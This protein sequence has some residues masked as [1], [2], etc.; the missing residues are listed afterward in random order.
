MRI[1]YKI[2]ICCVFLFS[3][4]IGFSQTKDINTQTGSKVEK[5]NSSQF[6]Q[7]V[8][9]FDPSMDMNEIQSLIDNLYQIQQDRKSEFSMKRY[10]L[11]FKPG[12]YRLDLKLGYYMQVLG[13][14]N[15]PEDVVINGGLISKGFD[16]GNVTLNFWRA[17]ENLTIKP[18]NNSPLIW[19]VSQGAQLRRVHIM[20]DIQLHDN[21]WA[22]GGFLADSKVDGTVYAGPQQQWFS[23][24]DDIGR[25]DGGSWNMMFV[26]VHNAPEGKFPQNPNT[27][28]NETPLVREK[29]YLTFAQGKFGVK[30]PRL[31][32]HRVGVSWLEGKGSDDNLSLDHFYVVKPDDHSESINQ[33]LKEGKNLL[34]TPGV[35]HIDQA[36]KV[37]RPNTLILGF[38]LATLVADHGNSIFDAADV[39]GLT[40]SGLMFNAGAITSKHLVQIGEASA[41]NGHA[42]KPTFLFDVFFRVGGDMLGSADACLIVNS[43]NVVIDHAWLWRADHGANVAWD[44]NTCKNGLIVNGDDVLVYGLFNEHFQEYQT[45]WNG[46]NGKVYFYQSELPYDPPKVDVWKHEGVGGYASYKVADH[47]KKHQAWGLGIY[48]V[49]YAA[50]IVVDQAIEV[51]ACVEKDIH[52]KILLWLNGNK[53]SVIK[54]IINGKGG[55]VSDANHKISME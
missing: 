6:G 35:Y 5:Y 19:G 33:A 11:L 39:D 36:I 38:G 9:L 23:R 25:W 31:K 34:F 30:V 37:V 13:L 45:L 32:A 1:F 55:S 22:S 40:I 2:V 44:K 43:K 27:V 26:G 20:G 24:N 51:P 54:S 28:M 42:L 17:V 8:Y 41:S 46:E 16:N 49:F 47:V 12:T 7:N 53:E 18:I 3:F 10:A 14:G 48:C 29:P 15:S 21:G 4:K 50:P 52:N